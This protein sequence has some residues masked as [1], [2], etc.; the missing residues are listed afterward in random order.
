MGKAG[1]AVTDHLGGRGRLR[2][3][4]LV[5]VGLVEPSAPTSSRQ[6]DSNRAMGGGGAVL[7]CTLS[8]SFSNSLIRLVTVSW[9]SA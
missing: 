4:A 8:V 1:P 7:S 5:R 3:S 9:A 6:A 2:G